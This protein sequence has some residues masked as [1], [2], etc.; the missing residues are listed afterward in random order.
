MTLIDKLFND[1]RSPLWR[2]MVTCDG[3]KHGHPCNNKPSL[4][5]ACRGCGAQ[6]LLCR[7]CVDVTEIFF[8][9]ET[10][11]TKCCDRTVASLQDALEIRPLVRGKGF[12]D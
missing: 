8:L 9:G 3:R 2:G 5:A 1:P 12:D 11:T 10:V 7:R 4:S 6:F